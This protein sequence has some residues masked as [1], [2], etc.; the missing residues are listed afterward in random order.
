MWVLCAAKS[1][2]G[3]MGLGRSHCIIVRDHGG[4][5]QGIPDWFVPR[6]AALVPA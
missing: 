2:D 4:D 3:A 1:V 6:N 5:A